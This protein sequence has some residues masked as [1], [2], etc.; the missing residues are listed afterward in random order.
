M[1]INKK[2]ATEFRQ[3][4]AEGITARNTSHDTAYGPL[5]DVVTDPT[6]AV[7]EQQNDR[8]RKVSLL[9]SLINEAEFDETDLNAFVF[10]EGLIRSSGAQATT[11]LTFQV[12]LAPTADATV[13]R[14]FPV[15]TQPDEATGTSITYVTTEEVTLAFATAATAFN[16]VTGFYELNVPAVATAAG[17]VGRVGANRVNRPL[18]TLV[19]FD[20]VTNKSATVGGLDSET[21]TELIERFL[22]AIVG[23]QLGTKKGIE[24][25]LLD[26]FPDVEDAHT[27]YGDDPLLLRAASDAGA[28]DT[29]VVGE[30]ATTGSD[31]L[32]FLG[33][34]QTMV[35]TRPP[36]LAVT[37]VTR[38]AP[39][40]TYAEDIDWE[41]VKDVSGVSGSTRAVDGIRFITGG[42]APSVGDVIVVAYTYNNL[43][44]S[45]QTTLDVEDNLVLGRDLL[46]RES[47]RVDIVLAATLTAVSNPV[48][49]KTLVEAALLAYVNAL[50]AGDD[51]EGSDLQGVVRRISGVDNFIITNLNRATIGVLSTVDL[52]IAANEYAR[53]TTANLNIT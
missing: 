35:I 20:A 39:A 5:R 16:A 29:F 26:E 9:L 6:A 10:N 52:P 34:G 24:R 36:L 7:L 51:V 18:R 22:L 53:M 38:A 37:S 30:Q 50:G 48:G 2:T 32:V 17:T 12:K 13:Q 28:V 23:R 27:I 47:V 11:T 8:A 44:R 33:V 21:N 3:D 46:G 45:M 31:N 40:A 42:N 43:I 1:P 14:G 41:T 15:A 19:G 25:F 49:T 4:L